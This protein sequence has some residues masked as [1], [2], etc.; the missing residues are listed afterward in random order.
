MLW[1]YSRG[2]DNR[3]VG[4]IQVW[5]RYD[6]PYI[7]LAS[8]YYFIDV[9]SNSLYSFLDSWLIFLCLKHSTNYIPALLGTNPL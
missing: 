2:V 9:R 5:H 6:K 1:N 8:T 4:V 7:T 3:A